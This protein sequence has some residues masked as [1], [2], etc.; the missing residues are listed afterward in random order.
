MSYTI[1]YNRQF[2]RS[3]AG[4]TPVWL[5]GESNVWESGAG[6]LRRSRAW[7]VFYNML[8]VTQEELLAAIQPSLGYESQHWMKNGR[9]VDDKALLHWVKL[10]CKRA[11]SIENI[12]L[13]NQDKIS[14][15]RCFLS[16]WEGNKHRQSLFKDVKSTEEFDRWLELAKTEITAIRAKKNMAFPIVDFGVEDL[17]HP[18]SIVL[19]DDCKVLFRH[20]NSY[21]VEAP[22]SD[23]SSWSEDIRKAHVFS[24]EEALNIKA[25]NKYGWIA[26]SRLVLAS[27]K[28]YPFDAVLRVKSGLYIGQYVMKRTRSKLHFTAIQRYAKHYATTAEAE[29]AKHR[30]EAAYSKRGITLEIVIDDGG[31]NE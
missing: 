2:I 6:H 31:G 28:E 16:I 25:E 27:I 8:G 13:E 7:S 3:A 10:G 23:S 20:K 1:E 15:V 26:E 9:W 22:S 14:N 19:R 30:I 5:A 18:S 21:L 17:R 11:A 4:I 24:Y 12:L 29:K